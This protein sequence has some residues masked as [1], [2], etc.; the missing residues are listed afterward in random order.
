[1]PKEAIMTKK[2]TVLPLEEHA[3]RIERIL[4]LEER[5]RFKL[6]ESLEDILK[7]EDLEK[8]KAALND[9]LNKESEHRTGVLICQAKLHG[10]AVTERDV[11]DPSCGNSDAS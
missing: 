7:L 5:Y 8:V 10:L 2:K 11:S 1:M 4:E 3:S 6:V 9:E